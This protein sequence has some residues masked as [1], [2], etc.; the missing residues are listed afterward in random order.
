MAP[1]TDPA[2]IEV[3]SNPR[4]E[5]CRRNSFK[6]TT[7]SKAGMMQMKNVKMTLRMSTT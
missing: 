4:L 7:G 5:A 6:P 2:P 3:K 1:T